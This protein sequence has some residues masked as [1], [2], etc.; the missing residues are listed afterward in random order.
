MPHS[1]E[2]FRLNS[3]KNILHPAAP[4]NASNAQHLQR[5]SANITLPPVIATVPFRS[6]NM[7]LS[8]SSIFDQPTFGV[9]V[10]GK[11]TLIFLNTERRFILENKH[12]DF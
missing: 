5:W 6:F 1:D 3:S 9:A 7:T 4:K 2:S 10:T 12:P 8:R 11:E